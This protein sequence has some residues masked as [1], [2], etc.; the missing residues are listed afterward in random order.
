M[1]LAFMATGCFFGVVGQWRAQ[2]GGEALLVMLGSLG[3]A[4]LIIESYY[5]S[6]VIVKPRRRSW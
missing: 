2:H 4:W 1:A 5:G 6:S 3:T